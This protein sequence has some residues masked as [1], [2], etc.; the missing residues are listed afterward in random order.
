VSWVVGLEMEG[1]SI[2]PR[3]SSSGRVSLATLEHMEMYN[4]ILHRHLVS[5]Y[6]GVKAVELYTGRPTD[7]D[8]PNTDPRV[9]GSD[10]DDVVDL[11]LSLAGPEIG[12]QVS[13]QKQSNEEAQRI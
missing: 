6:A 4:E 1:A 8:D 10:W 7:P 13:W 3:E 9:K 12:A 2:E 5:S 11:V